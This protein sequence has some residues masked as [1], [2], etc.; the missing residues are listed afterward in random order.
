MASALKIQELV[1]RGMLTPQE[2]ASL[3]LA[4]SKGPE[5]ARLAKRA[6]R[7]LWLQVLLAIPM[8]VFM[9]AWAACGGSER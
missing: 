3:L 4:K 1:S 2:G 9:V 6:K 8:L 5:E 7:P